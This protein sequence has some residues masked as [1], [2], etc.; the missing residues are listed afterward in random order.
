MKTPL[1]TN[2]Y[3]FTLPSDNLPCSIRQLLVKKGF[4][5][6][7]WRKLKKDATFFINEQ[8][9]TANDRLNAGDHLKIIV[10]PP[11][12]TVQ[13]ERGP[14]VVIF[15]DDYLLVVN[16]PPG[17]L[18]HPTGANTNGT[19][20][21]WLAYYYQQHK[22]ISAFHPIYRLDRNTSGLIIFAKQPFVQHL[23]SGNAIRKEYLALLNGVLPQTVGIIDAPI[24]RKTGSI[25]ER[26]IDFANGK[27]AQ[28]LYKV[29]RI[30]PKQ[31]S[32]VR[33]ILL[34]G[35]THQIRVH[36]AHLNCPLLH[37]TLYG[38]PGPQARQALHCHRISFIH[39]IT[40]K[41][42]RFF[43]PLPQDLLNFILNF[44]K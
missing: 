16:K 44:P 2:I 14:L 3:S 25:I 23:L 17:I 19:L 24:A 4:S 40:K 35:R 36:A 39:P 31:L 27:P 21:N 15:E 8:P 12:S 26:C 32:L 38:E 1:N 43:S 10:S 37:D 33:F 18:V 5:L 22:I 28:T 6:T 42:L 9:V 41:Q 30:Y 20:I 34:T 11:T 13:P 29:L 7:N